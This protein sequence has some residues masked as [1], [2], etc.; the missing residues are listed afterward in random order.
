LHRCGAGFPSRSAQKK[1]TV[2]AAASHE[3]SELG[4]GFEDRMIQEVETVKLELDQWR[5]QEKE[6]FEMDRNAL[7]QQKE[8]ELELARVKWE[9]EKRELEE[10]LRK[11]WEVKL[12]KEK[13]RIRDLLEDSKAQ[14]DDA[15]KSVLDGV[16]SQL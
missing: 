11:E 16:A 10:A 3:D 1:Q 14:L 15:G 5:Q 4:D 12:Q 7:E 2:P 8:A 6:K 13:K 9:Q